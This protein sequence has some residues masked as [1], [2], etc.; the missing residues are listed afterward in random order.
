M[1]ATSWIITIAIIFMI[2]FIIYTK[3]KE[4]NLRDTWEEVVS[5]VKPKKE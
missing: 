3:I 1:E 4:Q 2:L 5:L